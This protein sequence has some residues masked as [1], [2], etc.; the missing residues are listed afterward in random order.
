[1]ESRTVE[2]AMD[3]FR[4]IVESA[5]LASAED[6]NPFSA[7]ERHAQDLKSKF[8]MTEIGVI[9]HE[10][11]AGIMQRARKE[12]DHADR[13]VEIARVCHEV[14]R[15]VR[16]FLREADPGSSVNKP[17]HS[18]LPWNQISDETKA[19]ACVGVE[20][21]LSGQTETPEQS[22]DRWREFKESNGW[23]L[24]PVLDHEKKTHPNLV[25][26]D[27]LPGDEQIKDT[28]FF[29]IVRAMAP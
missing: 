26:Y 28:V 10:Q 25:P 19:S 14:N 23:T 15:A 18:D 21:I 27:E 1:M 2:Q 20:A 7:L 4:K 5:Y 9:Q 12:I 29:G 8:L 24:G 3:E 16:M 22:H 13:V 6:G 11:N 17:G